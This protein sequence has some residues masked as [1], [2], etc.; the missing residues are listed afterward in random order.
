[1]SSGDGGGNFFE[2]TAGDFLSGNVIQDSINW[3]LQSATGGLIG[4]KDGKVGPGFTGKAVVGGIKEITGAKAAEDANE[5][6]RK[7]IEQ[8]QADAMK[9]RA[10]ARYQAGLQDV[11]RSNLAGRARGAIGANMD[12]SLKLG[13]DEKDFLGL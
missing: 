9:A 1:M 10:D 13:S 12:A 3:G 8:T 7:Q 11:Q 6:A 2:N 4:F 5:L